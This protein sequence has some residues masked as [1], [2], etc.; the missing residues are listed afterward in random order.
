MCVNVAMD[1]ES[2]FMTVDKGMKAVETLVTAVLRIM[3]MS[4]GRMGNHHINSAL[5]PQAHPHAANHPLH[6]PVR[7]LVGPTVV[8]AASFQADDFEAVETNQFG[9]NIHTTVRRLLVIADIVVALYKK[10]GGLKTPRQKRQVFRRQIATSKNEF[11]FRKP[12]GVK[13]LVQ[14]RFDAIGYGQY[15]HDSFQSVRFSLPLQSDVDFHPWAN[16]LRFMLSDK[17]AYR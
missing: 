11:D 12:A 16:G 7:V 4:G 1:K 15:L 14:K 5:P 3:N 17:V 2:G 10:E 9:M 6:L 13:V 8:P